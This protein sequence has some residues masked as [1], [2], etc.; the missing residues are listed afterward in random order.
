MLAKELRNR[1]NNTTTANARTTTAQ[2]Q[3]MLSNIQNQVIAGSRALASKRIKN[4]S[5]RKG[6]ALEKKKVHHHAGHDS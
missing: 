4:E 1:D 5:N 2:K 3:K 6:A